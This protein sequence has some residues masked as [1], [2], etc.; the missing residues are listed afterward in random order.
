MVNRIIIYSLILLALVLLLVSTKDKPKNVTMTGYVI[1]K[2]WKK[3]AYSIHDEM[4]P[5]FQALLDNNDTV[6][7]SSN[8]RVGDS[9]FYKFYI[10]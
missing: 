2:V 8:N 4:S 9:V 3:K 10:K 7:C 1:T 6:P 5:R